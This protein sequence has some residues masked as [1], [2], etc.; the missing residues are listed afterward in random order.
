MNF[1]QSFIE[2]LEPLIYNNKAL[3]AIIDS[4]EVVIDLRSGV[5]QGCILSVS[6]FNIGTIP[7]ELAT[8][9]LKSISININKKAHFKENKDLTIEN[10]PSIFLADD[11]GSVLAKPEDVEGTLNIFIEFSHFSGLSYA[12]GKTRILTNSITNE[13]TN[14]KWQENF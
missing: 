6:L 4:Q 8:R 13:T 14:N 7:L 12:P 9:S 5:V 3:L 10:L 2:T 11:F 1:P